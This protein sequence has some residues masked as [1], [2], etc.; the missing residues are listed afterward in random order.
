[1]CVC[2]TRKQGFTLIEMMVVVTIMGLLVGGGVAAYTRFNERQEITQGVTKFVSDLRG[3]QKRADVGERPD[4]SVF[5]P[6]ED[7][8]ILEG[9]RVFST[10]G[11]TATVEAQCHDNNDNATILVTVDQLVLGP[12]LI[13]GGSFDMTFEVVSAG[14]I[15]A[16]ETVIINHISNGSGATITVNASGGINVVEN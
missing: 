11:T 5:A 15:N 8:D 9:Y 16:P 13:F 6:S 2:L 1:M 3:V 7:C 12:G 4:D 10:G 14:V